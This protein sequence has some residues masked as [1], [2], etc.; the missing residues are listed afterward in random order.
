MRSN[1]QFFDE[2]AIQAGN[3]Q[4]EKTSA[5][6]A[7]KVL[8][9]KQTPVKRRGGGHEETVMEKKAV[10]DSF[11]SMCG[12]AM[13]SSD[14]MGSD[15]QSFQVMISSNFGE[16]MNEMRKKAAVMKATKVMK[17]N[18]IKKEKATKKATKMTKKA[19]VEAKEV[20]TMVTK[21]TRR[22]PL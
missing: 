9:E 7:M 16:I 6:K 14:E 8:N 11:E 13:E 19:L 10:K 22:P 21:V 12:K 1:A 15:D 5:M 18:S 2:A 4:T 17:K 20:Q 3:G